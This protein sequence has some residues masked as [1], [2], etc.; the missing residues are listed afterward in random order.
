MVLA[1]VCLGTAWATPSYT[2]AGVVNAIDYSAGP[3]APN[4]VVSIFGSDL[5]RSTVASTIA[6]GGLATELGY[7]QVIVDGSPAPLLY[8][9]PGQINFLVPINHLPGDAVVR[10]FCQGAYGPEVTIHLSD[11]APTLIP[12]AGGY[13]AATH[14]N[15]SLITP[16]APAN[17]G[18][19]V[20]VYLVGLGKVSPSDGPATIPKSASWITALA[21]LKVLVAGT[22]VDPP[23]VFYAGLTPYFAGLYQINFFLPDTVGTDPE[24][25][26]AVGAQISAGGPKL[27]VK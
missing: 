19:S 23:R 17:G 5:S 18:E 13:V 4:S 16:D 24:I 22:V 1:L 21:D 25:R 11:A 7:T 26:V 15:G 9:S 20:V 6:S 14:A 27:A 2:A 10:V 3:F 8:V 12:A